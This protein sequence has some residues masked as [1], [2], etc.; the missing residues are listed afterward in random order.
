[1]SYDF[2][3][4]FVCIV[5]CG[6]AQCHGDTNQCTGST[7]FFQPGIQLRQE[8]RTAIS[9]PKPPPPPAPAAAEA[10]TPQLQLSSALYS[11]EPRASFVRADEFYLTRIEPQFDN[12]LDKFVD[13]VFRPEVFHIGKLPATCSIW[14]AIKRK[15]PLCL[16]NPLFFQ[17]SW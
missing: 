10:A 15:N 5:F 14:A 16:L 4:M 1:M 11:G 9:K 2:K 12:G 13:D 8:T 17:M 7:L 6:S 3:I